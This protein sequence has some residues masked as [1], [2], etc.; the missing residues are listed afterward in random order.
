V[1]HVGEFI[2][3]VTDQ[4]ADFGSLGELLG[5]AATNVRCPLTGF[6]HHSNRLLDLVR[7]LL[8][9]PRVSQHHRR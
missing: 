6:E 9:M 7:L 3:G 2:N 8:Q 1:T 4:L 5:S